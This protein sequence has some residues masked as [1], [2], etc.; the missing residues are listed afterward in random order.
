MFFSKGYEQTSVQNIIQ[1]MGVAKGTFYHYFDS[2]AELLDAVV[3]RMY[4]QTLRSL[5]PLIDDP[6][7]DALNKLMQ[8]IAALS[9]WKTSHR[10]LMIDTLR[11]L[12]R[13]ENI[14]LREKMRQ[15][16]FQATVP[17]LGR[18]IQQGVDEGIFDI[19]YPDETAQV[20]LSMSQAMRE[21][22]I[23]LFIDD[24]REPEAIARIY[25]QIAVYNQS[26]ERVLGMPP[27]SLTLVNAEVLDEW[28]T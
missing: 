13:D 20:I 26:V 2:K 8:F 14:P 7:I 12:Y 21:E 3:E 11:V 25:R 28:L 6:D 17:A 27:N 19:D 4:E 22:M 23:S 15:S 5:Q 9:Q 24:I 1:V 16:S 18:I 10:E